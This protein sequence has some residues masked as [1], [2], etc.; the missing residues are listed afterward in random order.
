MK[1]R[2]ELVGQRFGRLM[3]ISESR[4]NKHGGWYWNC[5]CDCGNATVVSVGHLRNGHTKS[6]GCLNQERI[7]KH[8]M[9]HTPEYKVWQAMMQRCRN[10]KYK[11]Y[12]YYGGR[13]IRVCK[14]WFKFENFYKDMGKRP[15]KNLTLERINNEKGYSLDNCVW[16]NW[17]SQSRNKRLGKRNTSGY[18]GVF[19][20]NGRKKWAARIMANYKDIYLGCFANFLDAVKARRNGEIKY[21]NK[22]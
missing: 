11:T 5:N 20:D 22:I 16:A 10:P 9:C 8:G 6:C 2:L 1:V 21:W 7:T 13:G 3:V 4:Q 19:W 17:V 15:T 18:M 12:A 14:H